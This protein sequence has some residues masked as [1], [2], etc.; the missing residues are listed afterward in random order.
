MKIYLI[1]LLSLFVFGC[2]LKAPVT[3]AQVVD[4][5]PRI[6]FNVS[7]YNPRDLE[8]F[9][10]QVSYGSLSKYLADNDSGAEGALRVIPGKHL[11]EVRMDRTIVFDAT[12]YFGEGTLRIFKVAP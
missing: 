5:R 6:S 11:I 8:L 9:V 7:K 3:S 1:A 4:D 12:D 10:D 2:A